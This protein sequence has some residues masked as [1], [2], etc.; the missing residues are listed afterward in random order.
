MSQPPSTLLAVDWGTSSLR[1]ARLDAQGHVLEEKSV[2]RGIQTVA[3]GEFATVF[4]AN[5]G[6]WARA[7][8]SFCLISGM[9]GSKQGWVE[10]P[11]CPCPAGF[12]EVAARLMWIA[13]APQGLPN[14]RIAIVPG[15]SCEHPSAVAGLTHIPD[16]MRGEEVQILGTMQLS[17]LR[18]GVFVLPGTHNKWAQVSDGRV[19]GFSTFMTG[20]FYALLSRLSILAKTVDADAP[21]DEAAFIQGVNQ[22]REGAGLLHNA[23]SARTL[24]LFSRMSASALASYLS[25]LIIGE[26]VGA[27][28]LIKGTSVNL[29]G[30]PAL[31]Q[32]YA[33]VLALHGVQSRLFGAEATW[34]GLFALSRSLG[35]STAPV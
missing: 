23:F 31:T 14:A 10:A 34:A 30:A 12:D 17:G 22:S 9:A 29:I 26:E 2:P 24:S 20:E 19:T 13:D 25:G 32:R 4:E 21:F 1:A 6:D 15:L 35:R 7:S 18:D 8:G 5:F 3:P 16:V 11:Y 27:Q 28:R 33:Q